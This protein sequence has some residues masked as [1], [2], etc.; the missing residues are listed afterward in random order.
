MK[1]IG[2]AVKIA[3]VTFNLPA[4]E[5]KADVHDNL[6]SHF[7]TNGIQLITLGFLMSRGKPK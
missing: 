7:F 4:W 3:F 2:R 1:Y 6:Y 5:R